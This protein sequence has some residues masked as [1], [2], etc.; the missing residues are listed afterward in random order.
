MHGNEDRRHNADSP[1]LISTI[2]AGTPHVNPRI[3]ST[4]ATRRDRKVARKTQTLP[5]FG[6]A[7]PQPLPATNR[8]FRCARQR[9]VLCQSEWGRKT[10][11]NMPLFQ[12]ASRVRAAGVTNCL[13]CLLSLILKAGWRWLEGPQ[14]AR[15]TRIEQGESVG[16]GG[17]GHR[18]SRFAWRRH[19]PTRK[20]K[21]G[22]DSRPR[23]QRTR[24]S[25]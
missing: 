10:F 6:R 8:V 25:C 16:R 13:F 22:R 20:R 7:A 1:R 15:I 12:I 19:G 5:S 18:L 9:D 24:V 17:A 3:R 14:R 11:P 23:L 21:R 2:Q 4:R